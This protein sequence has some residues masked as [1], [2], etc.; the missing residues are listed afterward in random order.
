MLGFSEQMQHKDVLSVKLKLNSLSG[1][2]KRKKNY[3]DLHKK[4]GQIKFTCGFLLGK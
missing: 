1:C 2:L 4:E 3:Y